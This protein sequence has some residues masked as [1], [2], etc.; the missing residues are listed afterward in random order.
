MI[1]YPDY[2]QMMEWHSDEPVILSWQIKTIAHQWQKFGYFLIVL[3]TLGCLGLLSSVIAYLITEPITALIIAIWS[4]AFI[5]IPALFLFGEVRRKCWIV[6]RFADYGAEICY[7]RAYPKSLFWGIRLLFVGLGIGVLITGIITKM[8]LLAI[9]GPVSIAL[10]LGSF[11]ITKNY[12]KDM[13]NFTWTGFGWENIIAAQYDIKC[14]VICLCSKIP[15]TPENSRY[16]PYH[17]SVSL[18]RNLHRQPTSA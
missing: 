11:A 18:L 2:T 3:L 15:L 4:S 6:Y 12:E 10:A 16:L 8:R 5:I 1:K 14:N 9:A 7:W 13:I 17:F